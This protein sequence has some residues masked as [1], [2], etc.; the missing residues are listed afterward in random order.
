MATIGEINLPADEF[1]LGY[2][3]DTIE[4][5]NVE[6]ERIAAHNPDTLMPYLCATSADPT[7]LEYVLAEDATVDAVEKVA[8][9]AADEA[10][11]QME[12]IDS[13]E[14]L[15]HILVEEDGTMLAAEGRQDG[16]FMRILFL[17]RAALSRTYEFCEENDIKFT[18]RRIYDVDEGKHGRFGLTDAQEET[19]MAAY[20][21]GYYDVPRDAALT[22]VA[23][24]V[25]VS[26]QSLSER[27]RRG[28]KNLVENSL[29]VGRGGS[30][31]GDE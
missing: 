10:L 13:V 5:V 14:V 6:V 31:D 8:Q 7:E 11:Y 27:L 20:D 23:A 15:V 4:D 30:D 9:P 26:H 1:A 12:W 28:H 19:I 17:D 3:L 21:H 16:W 25:G 2:T 18:L 29:I 22:E 24:A